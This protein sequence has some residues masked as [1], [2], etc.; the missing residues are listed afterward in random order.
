[1][2]T[3]DDIENHFLMEVENDVDDTSSIPQQSGKSCSCGQDSCVECC[4]G[5]HFIINSFSF[6]NIFSSFFSF[7]LTHIHSIFLLLY[8]IA[9]DGEVARAVQL[10]EDSPFGEG[11]NFTNMSFCRHD[12]CQEDA[13]VKVSSDSL[14]QEQVGTVEADTASLV[15]KHKDGWSKRDRF[16]PRR[17]NEPDDGWQVKYGVSITQLQEHRANTIKI[18]ESYR[19]DCPDLVDYFI[20]IIQQC[21]PGDN[22][23]LLLL[24]CA[25]QWTRLHISANCGTNWCLGGDADALKASGCSTLIA[26]N[27]LS[28][29]VKEYASFEMGYT[30]DALGCI[31]GRQGDCPIE[32]KEYINCPPLQ[33]IE[34]DPDVVVEVLTTVFQFF[35]NVKATAFLFSAGGTT[36]KVKE[37]ILDKLDHCNSE[38]ITICSEGMNHAQYLRGPFPKQTY[39]HTA[40]KNE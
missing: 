25:L 7:F 38:Y 33:D 39:Q 19:K 14:S 35:D 1:V 17:R 12:S 18:L 21:F 10:E 36:T 9:N 15:A 30:A 34:T 31:N 8:L 13:C 5:E 32:V 26:L 37:R 4:I 22:F 20:A 24:H 16:R 29:Y 27:A 2:N 40:K 3:N 28:S 6:S 23:F 11:V